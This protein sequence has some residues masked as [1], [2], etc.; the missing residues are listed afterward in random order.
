MT[1]NSQIL[2]ILEQA[3]TIPPDGHEGAWE[4]LLEDVLNLPMCYLASV[5]SA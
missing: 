4:W 5:H 2:A 3:A 1:D